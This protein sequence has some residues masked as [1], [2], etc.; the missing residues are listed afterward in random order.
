MQF[1]KSSEKKFPEFFA[2]LRGRGGELADG[3]EMTVKKIIGEVKAEGDTALKRY[4]KQFDGHENIVVSADT[5][6]GSCKRI[7]PELMKSLELAFARIE[8]YHR[9][10][11]QQSWF[12]TEKSGAVTGQVIRPLERIGVYVPGGKA[13]YPSSVLMNVVPAIVAGVNEII[14]V[15]PGSPSG[16]DPV[17]LAAAELCGITKIFQIGGAQAVAALAYGTG[18]VP[19]VDKIVGPGNIYVAVAKKQVFGDV[20]IDM[21]AGPSEILIISDGS[22]EPAWAA[23]DMLSQAEHDEMASSVL[24][25]TDEAFGKLVMDEINLQIEQLPRKAI[26]RSSIDNYGSVIVADSLEEAVRLSNDIA[27]EHLELYVEDPWKLLPFINNA[28]AIFMGHLTPEPLG[29]YA[30]GPNHVLPTGGTARFF[31]PLSVDDYVK[32][33]SLLCFN[34]AGLNQIGTDVV[35][36]ARSEQLEAHARSVEIRTLKK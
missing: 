1:C 28:G 6:T 31:S 25:T 36:L 22:G 33:M 9:R 11:M 19:R 23:A 35:R 4:T 14:M 10:Q 32:K 18:I 12:T 2:A 30:A 27:P 3:V 13:L 29:D 20:D 7:S 8:D 17:I 21:I 26:A 34:D 15:T 24:V 16:I 5:I